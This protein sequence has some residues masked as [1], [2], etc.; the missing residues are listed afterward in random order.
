VQ[1]HIAQFFTDVVG[2][3]G[4]QSRA[5]LIDFFYRIA[6]QTLVGLFSIPRTLLTQ[7]F[8]HVQQVA[9]SLQY[10]VLIFL[11]FLRYI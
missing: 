10:L 2:I 1:Q 4:H 11:H 7:F 3:I 8:H 9:K 6:S 5:Q